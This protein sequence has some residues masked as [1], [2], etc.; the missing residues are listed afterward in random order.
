MFGMEKPKK[1]EK[2]TFLFDLEKDLRD[3]TKRK[4]LASRIESRILRI[5]E[6]LRKGSKK[7]DYD[8]LA[9]LLNGYHSMAIVLSRASQEPARKSSKL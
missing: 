8:K 4:E 3:E 9:V 6:L 2:S 1:E 7:E 5:K